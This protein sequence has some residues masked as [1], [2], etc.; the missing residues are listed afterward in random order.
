MISAPK[1]H[2]KSIKASYTIVQD[3]QVRNLVKKYKLSK[4]QRQQLHDLIHHGEGYGYDEIEQVIKDLF[5][6]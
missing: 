6:L 5:G 1:E 2:N 3:K 4:D